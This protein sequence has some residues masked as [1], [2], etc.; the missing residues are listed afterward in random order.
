LELD[1][2]DADCL[3]M[4]SDISMLNGYPE[5]GLEEATKRLNSGTMNW[6]YLL[7]GQAEY[8]FGRYEDAILTLRQEQNYRAHARRFLAAMQTFFWTSIVGRLASRSL[9]GRCAIIRPRR[10]ISSFH[11]GGWRTLS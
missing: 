8:A 11:L 9:A 5:R 3:A 6:Y 10:N 7:K 2:N 4:K 1:P